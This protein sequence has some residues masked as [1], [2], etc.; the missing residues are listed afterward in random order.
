MLG[1]DRTGQAPL[2]GLRQDV[3]TAAILDALGL[4]TSKP[5]KLGNALHSAGQDDAIVEAALIILIAHPSLAG[6]MHPFE[7]SIHAIGIDVGGSAIDFGYF[8]R[9][10]IIDHFRGHR[11]SIGVGD[12]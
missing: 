7:F 2:I 5:I 11:R 12:G 1:M 9:N 6:D 4:Q 3:G 8:P 10:R